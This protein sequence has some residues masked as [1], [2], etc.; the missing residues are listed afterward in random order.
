MSEPQSHAELEQLLPA[1]ALEVLEGSEL[2][3]VTAHVREC[4]Q[5]ALQLQSYREV[6]ADLATALP[7]RALDPERSAR[8]RAQLLARAIGKPAVPFQH[9]AAPARSAKDSVGGW[10]GWAGWAVAAG[11]SGVLFI[12]HSVHRPLAYGWLV[13]GILTLILLAV[14]LQLR[15]QRAR[16]S[17]LQDQVADSIGSSSSPGVSSRSA[18]P[19]R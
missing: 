4:A 18:P 2:L 17:A 11:L 15:R 13:A 7:Q 10:A 1:A 9:A 16:I 8:L 19:R 12:H 3:E 14:V 5:C 6:V